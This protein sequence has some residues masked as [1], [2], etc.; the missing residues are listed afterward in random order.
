M[1]VTLMV[2]FACIMGHW[3]GKGQYFVNIHTHSPVLSITFTWTNHS[4]QRAKF[5]KLSYSRYSF[6]PLLIVQY[7]LYPIWICNENDFL[8]SIKEL[9]WSS[10]SWHCGTP[11]HPLITKKKNHIQEIFSMLILLNLNICL[12]A[13]N[14]LVKIARIPLKVMTEKLSIFLA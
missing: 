5:H 2:Y 3:T 12:S 6:I 4:L 1:A 14:K 10:I 9:R 11:I 8:A 7:N 13:R